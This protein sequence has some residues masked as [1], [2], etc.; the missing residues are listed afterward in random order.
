MV[1]YSC[2]STTI[3]TLRITVAAPIVLGVASIIA[4]IAI[5]IANVI[6]YVRGSSYEQAIITVDVAFVV[7]GMIGN[8]CIATLVTNLIAV[9]GVYMRSCSCVA[10]YVTAIVALV[11]VNVR[12]Y[13]DELTAGVVTLGIA[14]VVPNVRNGTGCATANYV[15][16]CITLVCPLVTVCSTLLAAF[17]TDLIAIVIPDVICCTG[18]CAIITCCITAVVEDVIAV[19]FLSAFVTDLVF[20]AIIYV[21]RTIVTLVSAFGN[22][23]LVVTVAGVLVAAYTYVITIGNVTICITVVIEFVRYLTVFVTLITVFIAIVIPNVSDRTSM[24]AELIVTCCIAIIIEY[25]VN[26]TFYITACAFTSFIASMSIYVLECYAGRT[27]NATYES[28]LTP[29]SGTFCGV[30]SV[31][32]TVSCVTCI[33]TFTVVDVIYYT[34]IRTS[35]GITISVAFMS[36]YVGNS[37]NKEAGAVVTNRI[38]NTAKY[39]RCFSYIVTQ[40]TVKVT[41]IGINVSSASCSTS[42]NVTNFVARIGPIVCDHTGVATFFNITLFFIALA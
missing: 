37:T 3:I 22:V 31:L 28:G 26:L 6:E 18:K 32:G 1:N 12:Y 19:T 16:F 17:V 35:S 14:N 9:E 39:V 27:V 13:T 29:L 20:A 5:G 36:E 38:T 33:V 25:V 4:E 40:I 23:T 10:T 34:S 30:V 42:R 11:G 8:A 7:I 24:C 41:G 21:T 15:T 2:E